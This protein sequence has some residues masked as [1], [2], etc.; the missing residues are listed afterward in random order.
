MFIANKKFILINLAILI[1][2]QSAYSNF[3]WFKNLPFVDKPMHFLGG[4]LAVS[5][6]LYFFEKRPDLFSLPE[7][8][9][10]SLI[11]IV[12]FAALIGLLWEFYEYSVEYYFFRL[13]GVTVLDMALGDTLGDLFFDL[14]GGFAAGIFRRAGYEPKQI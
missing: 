2:S 8:K 11:I 9:S 4:V 14:L 10:V 6:L 12:S 7:N 5:L 3:E 13:S 1:L